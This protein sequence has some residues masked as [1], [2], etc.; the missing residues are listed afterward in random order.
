M[1]KHL[2]VLGILVFSILIL[3]GCE[4]Q[5]NNNDDND[6]NSVDEE[7]DYGFPHIA[8]YVRNQEDLLN[9]Q[10]ANFDIIYSS[11]IDS[12]AA[13]VIKQRNSETIILYQSP[14]SYMFDSA[15]DVIETTT[16]MQI[17]DDFWLKDSS[18]QRCG[19]GWTPEIW[20][21]DLS[22]PE[23][24]EIMASFFSSILE[25]QTH[26]DGLFFDIIEE[27]SRCDVLNDSEWS[28]YNSDLL[29]AIRE[30]I[31]EKIIITNSGYNYSSDAPFL[32]HINGYAM[33]SFLSGGAVY[34]VGLDAIDTVL[35]KTL[36]PHYL[37]FSVYSENTATKEDIG[38]DKFRLA[39]TLSM[40]YDNTYLAYHQS[41]AEVATILWEDEFSV[42]LGRP[43]ST[44]YELGNSYV[45]E[46]EKGVVISSPYA[47]FTYIFDDE[48]LDVSTGKVTN[49]I[50]VDRNDGKILLYNS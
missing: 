20:A 28:N 45:R 38:D 30:K 50:S 34:N 4:E 31:G 48:F 2:L 23:N 33:E 22:N 49:T 7:V 9:V 3:S 21:I 27:V 8:C 44:I 37:I 18:D 43:L 24:I 42:D 16:G 36:E 35:E 19:Y 26:Y 40:M 14:A 10:D 11:D 17:T 5:T 46:F 25:T 29:E 1:K 6:N 12:S 39:L 47:S 13:S 41:L 32:K 15:V